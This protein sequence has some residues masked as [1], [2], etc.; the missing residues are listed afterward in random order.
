MYVIRG[1]MPKLLPLLEKKEYL[2]DCA[3]TFRHLRIQMEETRAT[4][5]ALLAELQ[6]L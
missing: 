4:Q 3:C 1:A 2:C 6:K 5:V